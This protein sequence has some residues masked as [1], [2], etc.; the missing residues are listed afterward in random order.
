MILEL[1]FNIIILCNEELGDET[2]AVTA[3]SPRT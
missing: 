3:P 1:K 2:H